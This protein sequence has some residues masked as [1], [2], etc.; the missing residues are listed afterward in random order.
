[1]FIRDRHGAVNLCHGGNVAGWRAMLCINRADQRGF[2]IALNSDREGTQY[3]Q[4]D[5]RL[6]RHLGLAKAAPKTA[7]AA[8]RAGDESWSGLYV[9][10]PGRLQALALPDR[11]LGFWHLS[12]QADRATLRE[13]F[14]PPRELLPAGAGLYRQGDRQ[15]ATLALLR[16]AQ[17]TSVL[18]GGYL[19]LR[20]VSLWEQGLLWASAGIGLV[21]FLA[22]PPLAVLRVW[23]L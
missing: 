9:P 5:D 3:T 14:A 6:V 13:G 16:D 19:T 15:Q 12:I 8:T 18:G 21:G 2:F 20:R 11:L 7:P 17:G 4:F 22:L 1:M 23:R 10:A